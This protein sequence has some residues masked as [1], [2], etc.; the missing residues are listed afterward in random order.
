MSLN[1]QFRAGLG[2]SELA[3]STKELNYLL[4]SRLGNQAS[5]QNEYRG[6]KQEIIR[7]ELAKKDTLSICQ[8]SGQATM[9]IAWL[10]AQV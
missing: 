2:E 1:G 3:I 8:Y 5:E 10:G 7:M 9:Q 6:S 4:S